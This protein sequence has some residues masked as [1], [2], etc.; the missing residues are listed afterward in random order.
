M[1][2]LRPFAEKIATHLM[3]YNKGGSDEVVVERMASMKLQEDGSE[4]NLGGLGWE[5]MTRIIEAHLV[6]AFKCG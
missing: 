5:S 1:S 6:E 2:D 4:I 3:T